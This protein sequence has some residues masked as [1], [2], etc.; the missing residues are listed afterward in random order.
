MQSHPTLYVFDFSDMCYLPEASWK[1]FFERDIV[2]VSD[3]IYSTN[4]REFQL[5][6]LRANDLS[7]Q[8]V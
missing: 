7:E 5:V 3:C 2:L 4:N 8:V 1:G 6:A